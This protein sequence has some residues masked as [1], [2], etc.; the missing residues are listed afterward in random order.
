MGT[1][2]HHSERG[3][4]L[5]GRQVVSQ[6]CKMVTAFKISSSM[7]RNG[8]VVSGTPCLLASAPGFPLVLWEVTVPV[9]TR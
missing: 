8:S 5:G 1:E 6:A 9:S 3:C 2:L 7:Q 4:V